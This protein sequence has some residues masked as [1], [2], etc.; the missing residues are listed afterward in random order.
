MMGR[1]ILKADLQLGSNL[2]RLASV[3]ALLEDTTLE[4]E[5]RPDALKELLAALLIATDPVSAWSSCPGSVPVQLIWQL[6]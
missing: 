6:N 5:D 1:G 3:I 2:L 4:D